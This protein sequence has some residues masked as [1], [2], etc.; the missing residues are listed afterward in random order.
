MESLTEKNMGVAKKMKVDWLHLSPLWRPAR[1]GFVP[2]FF[3]NSVALER[4]AASGAGL[5][6]PAESRGKKRKLELLS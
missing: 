4:G 1:I 3:E 2:K 5:A 6:R